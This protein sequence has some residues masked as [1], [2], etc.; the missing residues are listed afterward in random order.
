M[1]TLMLRSC[2]V[3]T[4]VGWKIIGVLVSCSHPWDYYSGCGGAFG[5][6]AAVCAVAFGRNSSCMSSWQGRVVTLMFG[7]WMSV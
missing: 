1:E 7:L 2:T 6:L 5:Q 4:G 3:T